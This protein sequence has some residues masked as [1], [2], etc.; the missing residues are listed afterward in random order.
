MSSFLGRILRDNIDQKM[1]KVL[2]NVDF[3][4]FKSK[5]YQ[6]NNIFV[7]HVCVKHDCSFKYH[8]K[9]TDDP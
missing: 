1:I 9:S 4:S 5:H 3:F 7:S 2:D 6:R 8:I